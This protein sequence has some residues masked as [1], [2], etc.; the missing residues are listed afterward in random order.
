[1]YKVPLADARIV[2]R[3]YKRRPLGK[4]EAF[5]SW[6]LDKIFNNK[7]HYEDGRPV[8]TWEQLRKGH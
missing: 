8:P 1:M 6:T 7:G 2:D 5:L 3:D 4:V